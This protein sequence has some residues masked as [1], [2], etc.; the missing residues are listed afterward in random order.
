MNPAP[1]TF[2]AAALAFSTISQLSFS[3]WMTSVRAVLF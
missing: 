3:T 1:G 2:A